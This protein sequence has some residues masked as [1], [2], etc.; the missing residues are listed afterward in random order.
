MKSFDALGMD[1]SPAVIETIIQMAI[2]EQEGV[3]GLSN[4]Q[5]RKLLSVFSRKNAQQSIEMS[6]DENEQ[7]ELNL[8]IDVYYG[9]V[10]PEV[11]QALRETIAEALKGQL[12]LELT[13]INIC[14]DG[15]RFKK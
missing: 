10:L 3:A 7:I 1:I 11:A 9:A 6:I 4:P 8:H 2:Q 13:T 5:T 12:G 14:I 15:L